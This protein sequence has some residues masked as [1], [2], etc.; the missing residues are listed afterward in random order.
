MD[1]KTKN[2]KIILHKF[3]DEEIVPQMKLIL[4]ASL[5]Q[6]IETE[7]EDFSVISEKWR[8]ELSSDCQKA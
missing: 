7:Q 2:S 4:E 6:W 3:K 1:V 5:K 8:P